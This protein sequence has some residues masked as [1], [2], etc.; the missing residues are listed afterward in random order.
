M[1]NIMGIHQVSYY[2]NRSYLC[3]ISLGYR[4]KTLVNKAY[5]HDAQ[6][7]KGWANLAAIQVQTPFAKSLFLSARYG[8]AGTPVL[9]LEV[10]KEG[11]RM[12]IHTH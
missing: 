1:Q 9:R 8:A 7:P 12:K 4:A 10:A 11:G 3:N 5:L 6:A 2:K